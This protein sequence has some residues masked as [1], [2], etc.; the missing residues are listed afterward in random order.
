MKKVVSLLL[1]LCLLMTSMA[2]V[3]ASAGAEEPI[4]VVF[5]APMSGQDS[6][7]AAYKM[8]QEK[9][10]EE[11]GVLVEAIR[12][13]GTNDQEKLNM[14][15]SSGQ[16]VDVWWGDYLTY[17]SN[18][19]VQP[20]NGI[21]EEYGPDAMRVWNDPTWNG[22]AITTDA[23]GT[24]W[25]I[26]RS[27]NRVFYQTFVRQDFLDALGMELPTNLDELEKYLYAVKELDPVGNGE[28]IPL[29]HRGSS[30]ETLAYHFLGGFTAYGYSNWLDGDGNIKPPV[31]QE[32]YKDFIIKMN[33]WYKDGI[34][35]KENFGW[36]VAT[37]QQAIAAGRAAASGAYSTDVTAQNWNMRS[38]VPTASWADYIDG[39]T[40]PNGDK[41][42]TLIK[43]DAFA[44]LFNSRS[45][46][47]HVIAAM[48]VVN[49]CYENW[50]NFKIGMSGIEGVHWEYNSEYPDAREKHITVTLTAESK[51]N[52]NF[53]FGIGLPMER[54]CVTYD[55]DGQRNMHNEY[56]GHQS[57]L[58]AAKV[59][60][61]I[62]VV[63]N[64]VELKENI[65]T[66]SDIERMLKEEQVKFV[67][68]M[69]DISEWDAFIGELYNAGMDD[70]IAEYTR[71]YNRAKGI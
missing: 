64:S 41:M 11:T 13:S 39:M 67:M 5:V 70:W 36:D 28:T 45:D 22:F 65:I 68:G 46:E 25:G 57:N 52:G 61:D 54:D 21:V 26:P 33:Q 9:I 63:Y 59:P 40:G 3:V 17:M 14:M 44:I 16:Q 29:I 55:P 32:G 60:V 20:I 49:W 24:I 43:A 42:E 19:M 62:N 10:L 23:E 18:G 48:K 6:D 66:L 37:V 30:V 34:L 1:T 27:V 53:W 7:E 51:Y 35:H 71:Q 50:D 31:L 2:L 4:K 69:R 47:E 58:F 38:A 56:M 12:L 8:V 15:L